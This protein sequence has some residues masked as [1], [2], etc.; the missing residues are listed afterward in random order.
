MTITPLMT[1]NGLIHLENLPETALT[2][3]ALGDTLAKNNLVVS[4]LV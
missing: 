3:E 4:K 2:A 1:R